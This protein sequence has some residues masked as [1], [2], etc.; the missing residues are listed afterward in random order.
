MR[1]TAGVTGASSIAGPLP[2]CVGVAGTR[3]SHEPLAG[4]LLVHCP[5]VLLS[6]LLAD[7]AVADSSTAGP[8]D[9]SLDSDLAAGTAELASAAAEAA[10]TSA[11]QPAGVVAPRDA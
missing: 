11:D 7:G 10:A 1:S 3:L 4:A 9:L 2:L 5:D 6:L 8:E